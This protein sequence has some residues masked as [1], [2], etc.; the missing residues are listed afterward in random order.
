MFMS[1][2]ATEPAPTTEPSNSG[3]LLS[4]IRALIEYGKQLVATLQQPTSTT[5]IAGATRGFGTRD[6]ALILARIARGLQRADALEARLVRSATQLDAAA[7]PR[8]AVAAKRVPA[9]PRQAAPRAASPLDQLPTAEQIAAEVR[10]RPIGAVVADI[11]R[12]LG[13]MPSHPLWR[14]VHRVILKHGG[15]LAALVKDI[16]D[17]VLPLPAREVAPARSPASRLPPAG[18]GPPTYH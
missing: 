15:N 5:D 2:S 6:I 17:R 11:C 3:R 13:I 1:A 9:P 18:T 7:K 4:L 14:E 10:R 8:G 16:L 12:D